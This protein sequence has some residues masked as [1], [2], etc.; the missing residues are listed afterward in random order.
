MVGTIRMF[1]KTTLVANK[2]KLRVFADYLWRHNG[3]IEITNSKMDFN[4]LTHAEEF[5]RVGVVQTKRQMEAAVRST[6]FI[7]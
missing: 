3:T 6:I 7:F 2:E 1:Q 4:Q 5:E